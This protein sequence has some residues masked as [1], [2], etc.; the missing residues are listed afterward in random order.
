MVLVAVSDDDAL[1]LLVISSD[2]CKIRNNAVDARHV[3]FR[4]AHAAVDDDDVVV[5]FEGGHVLADLANA[6]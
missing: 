3:L 1:K 5:V 2:V 4:E 6:A